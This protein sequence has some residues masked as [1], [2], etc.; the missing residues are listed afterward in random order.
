MPDRDVRQ[1]PGIHDILAFVGASVRVND[2]LEDALLAN[3]ALGRSHQTAPD[4]ASRH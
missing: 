2:Q 3:D 1:Q 4:V